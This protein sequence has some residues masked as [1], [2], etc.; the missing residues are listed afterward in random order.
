MSAA[1]F[2]NTAADLQKSLRSK[3]KIPQV[4]VKR[5]YLQS[6]GFCGYDVWLDGNEEVK[7]YS[8]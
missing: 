1:S 5:M 6:N 3:I 4:I 8:K 2:L 7:F